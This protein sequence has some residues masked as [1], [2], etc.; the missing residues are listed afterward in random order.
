VRARRSCA[1]SPLRRC[2]DH[3]I[4]FSPSE[5]TEP[6]MEPILPI[7][8]VKH[9][10]YLQLLGIFHSNWS[11]ID[12]HTDF[13]ICQFLHV[14][15]QQAHLI[16]SGMMFG[17]KARLLA[18]LI[19]NSDDGRKQKLLEAFKKIRAAKREIIT[20]S[21]VASDAASVRYLE[22]NISGPFKAEVHSYSAKELHD[23]V[24]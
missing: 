10:S 16:T 14:T 4:S 21:Y 15:Q 18:D 8:T 19:R 5:A 24:P 22:R 11:A 17:R 20:H 13:A 3:R 7:P 12:L 23:H 2:I 6:F 1:A 9:A